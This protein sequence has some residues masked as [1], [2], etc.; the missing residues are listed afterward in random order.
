MTPAP[1]FEMNKDHILYFQTNKRDK[2]LWKL[3]NLEKE[4]EKKRKCKSWQTKLY[5]SSWDITFV[6]SKGK[7]ETG[8]ARFT[9]NN[10]AVII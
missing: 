10:T 8:T 6:T 2:V 5:K 9:C 7:L 1:L 3:V 4:K